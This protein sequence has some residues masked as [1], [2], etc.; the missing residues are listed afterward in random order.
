MR[1]LGIGDMVDRVITL[2]RSRP[3]VFLIVSAIPYL[4]LSI[5]FYGLGSGYMPLLATLSDPSTAADPEALDPEALSALGT[6]GSGMG[7]ASLV[8]LSVQGAALVHAAADGYHA[9]PGS[10]GGSLAAGL[11]ASLRI[12]GAGC[13]AVFALTFL[14]VAI[15]VGA[16]LTREPIVFAVAAF[17]AVVIGLYILASWLLV[18]MVATLE[19]TGP[20]HS[21]RR[22][23]QLSS[24]SRWRVL[25]LLVLLVILQI[26]LSAIFS[27]VFLAPFTADPRIRFA[28][29]GAVNV[30]ISIAWAPIY[31]G[32]Y[33]LLYYDLRVRREGYDL[34]IAAEALSREP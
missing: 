21:L 4:L 2:Y 16:A 29:Q 22:S 14:I 30:L 6:F 33:T 3:L 15:F 26:V 20:L 32:T 18:P 31:Y 34:S 1:P 17:V 28:V 19:G 13:L 12:M 11:R 10:I 25:A 5:A 7:L 8:L 27:L 23:W 9:R 24:R